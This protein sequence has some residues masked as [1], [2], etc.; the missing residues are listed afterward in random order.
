MI[1]RERER[2]DN[3]G[4]SKLL[5]YVFGLD[6]VS[7]GYKINFDKLSN[8]AK[9][10]KGKQL[11]KNKLLP[12]GYPVYNGGVTPTGYWNEYNFHENKITIAQGGS[13]G[14]VTW[15]NTKFWA[16]AHLYV[17]SE[18]NDI[19]NYKYLYYVIKNNQEYLMEQKHG[20]TI[21]ALSMDVVNNL[22]IPIPPLSLQNQIVA[23]LDNFSTYTNNLTQGLPAEITLRQK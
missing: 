17:I 3:S 9:C 23:I 8:V 1:L 18:C 4:L 11:N 13:A 19:L 6:L 16:S 15:Q 12:E 14:F 10:V 2:D 20:T 22:I 21:P 7:Y 5:E